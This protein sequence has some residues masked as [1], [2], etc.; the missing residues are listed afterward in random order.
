MSA[1]LAR[2]R[3]YA[4]SFACTALLVACSGT[5]RAN[6]PRARREPLFTRLSG[7]ETGIRF[8]NRIVETN[9]RNVFTYRNFYN[10][11]GVA[12][13]DLTGDGLPE[14][15]LTSN[16]KGPRLF[17]NQGYFRFRD[18]TE[19]AGLAQVTDAWTTGV[20]LADVDGDGR[21]DIYVCRAGP[22]LPEKRGNALWIN[23]GLDSTGVPTFRDM[24]REYGVADQGFGTQAVFLDYDRDGDLDLF[25][26]NNSPRPVSSF[27]MT[28]TRFARDASGGAKLF[29]NDGGHFTDVSLIAGIHSPVVAFVLG[30]AVGDVNRDG[31]PDIYVSNDFFERDYLYINR[32]DGTFS[33]ALD[34]QMPVVSYFSMGLDIADLDD[35]GWPDV[36]TTDMLPEDEFRL[37]LTGTFESWDMY[38]AKVRN[39]YHHQ[40]MRNMLQRNNRDGTFSDV[41]QL[42]GVARTDWSWSALIADLDL[43]GRKDI[44]V[45]NGLAKDVTS[46]DYVAFLANDATM[47]EMTRGGKA[48]VD[49]LRLTSAMTTTPIPNYAFR[50]L[51]G[52]HF[53]SV[54]SSWGLATPSI[55]SGAAYGDLDGD[56][57]LD[58]VVNNVN[59][60]AFVCRNDARRVYPEHASLRVRLVGEGANRFGVGA[61]VTLYTGS[62]L[63]MQEQFPTRGFQSSVD[64][65]LV[66][67]LGTR[68]EPDSLVVEWPDGRTSVVVHPRAD[69]LVDVRQSDAIAGAVR[70]RRAS[71]PLR[72][73]TFND[74]SERLPRGW[75][76]R[77][78]DFVDF[79]REPLIPRMVSTEG[80]AL[81]VGDVDGDGLDDMYI[82]GAKDQAGV[83]LVQRRDG[84]F[85]P[86]SE[87]VFAADS[88]F[89]DVGAVFFDADGDGDLDLYVVSG[90][91][92]FAEGSPQLQDRLYLNDGR[93]NFR[94]A[95]DALP[96]EGF[97]GSRAVAA[98]FDGDGDV[99]LFVGG[100]VVPGRYGVDPRSMLLL[101]DGKGHFS[102]A[103]DA[104]AQGLARVGM[105]T[106]A[107]WGDVDGDGRVDLVVVGEW[108]P[109][110]IFRNRG[111]GTLA[112]L[113]ARGLTQSHG[114]WNRIV[115]GDFDGDGRIDFVVGNLGLNARLR[116]SEREPTTMYVADFDD[117]G[118]EEQV[119]AYSHGGASYPL[120]MRDE[121]VRALPHLESR[122]PRYA[123]Y[124]RARLSDVFRETEL[125]GA[126]QKRA[127][128]F[129]TSLVRNDGNGSF[130]VTPLPDEAQLAPV[131][132]LAA[133]DVDGDGRLDLLL[134]GNLDGVKPEIGRLSGSYGLVLYGDGS[135]GFTAG[136]PVDT[137]F[138]IPGQTRDIQRLRTREGDLY[139]VARNDDRP[140]AFT[141]G[142][143]NLIARARGQ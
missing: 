53:A 36:Y 29:R 135:G 31:W 16:Q 136:R 26:L 35:D 88:A 45:T 66:F 121:L 75:R 117:D 28:N 55:S 128:I 110:T 116:A 20:T 15:V 85:A 60:E 8:E 103:T 109:I 73:T 70:N 12:I 105:V 96:V 61:R 30:I 77:E 108:M 118:V 71:L 78:N 94:R 95:V 101:N 140:L 92:E 23:Q 69:T 81:A 2:S 127:N 125:S 41:G 74:V 98:D 25:V 111:D 123:D 138:F 122:F 10:G 84:S 52:L 102:D 7:R 27:G 131:Y 9:E 139:V 59:D 68:H 100:R 97:S 14:I 83:L 39:G 67:G 89:E 93:G 40:L 72:A 62:E 99:D 22:F 76:H 112:R 37:R 124:A 64:Y 32:R 44:F 24:A 82:G 130:T 11:G 137:G 19:E 50:N 58:L 47:K 42:A 43:D 13:G 142:R 104:R 3:R 126:V 133:A 113:D 114:W 91:N 46:Q 106:D 107:L 1:L 18:V 79:A 129:A 49:F 119:L 54:A 5:G 4:S 33:E 134:G 51:G 6:E 63:Q 132:G 57:A 21:L 141:V 34:T 143:R 48:R 87:P 90:G 80:P 38:E 17:L 115:A 86:R 120:P 56:G 65:V